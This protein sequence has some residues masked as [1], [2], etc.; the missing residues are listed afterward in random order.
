[1]IYNRQERTLLKSSVGNANQSY[2]G[3]VFRNVDDAAVRDMAATEASSPS[4]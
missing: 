1:M 2:R 3:R 4:G